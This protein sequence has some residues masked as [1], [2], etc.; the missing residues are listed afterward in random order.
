MTFPPAES[1]PCSGVAG[2]PV[3]YLTPFLVTILVEE[4]LKTFSKRCSLNQ[5]IL[6]G[7]TMCS[8][9][10]GKKKERKKKNQNL[11]LGL[12]RLSVTRRYIRAVPFRFLPHESNQSTHER[13]HNPTFLNHRRKMLNCGRVSCM[14]LCLLSLPLPP[15]EKL[16][17]TVSSRRAVTCG[18][19]GW[20]QQTQCPCNTMQSNDNNN[21]TNTQAQE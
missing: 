5:S 17:T 11:L 9:H 15:P 18:V 13:L 16:R 21:T 10:G 4:A 6:R 14:S 19:G 3:T 2:Q 7:D 8:S 12:S 1:H 20:T